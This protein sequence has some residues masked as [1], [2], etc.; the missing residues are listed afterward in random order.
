MRLDSLVF[1]SAKSQFP[2]GEGGGE[3]IIR[4]LL[5]ALS[6]RGIQVE[7]NGAWNP[8]KASL[9]EKSLVELGSVLEPTE[10]EGGCAYTLSYP[11]RLVRREAFAR[12]VETR[13]AESDCEVVLVQAVDSW[14]AIEAARRLGRVPIFYAQN[15][16]ELESYPEADSLP[17]V[18]ANSRYFQERLREQYSMPVELL[19][20]AVDLDKYR[21]EENS[22]RYI[23]MINPVVI[24][25]IAYVLKLALAHPDREFLVVEG[26]GTPPE[27][28][29]LIERIG[30]VTWWD[31]QV[32]MRA[33]YA[34]TDILLV[35]SQWNEAFG[36]V[37]TEAQINGIPVLASR[38][39]GIPESLGSGGVLVEEIQNP[40][41]WTKGLAEVVLRY[42]ELSALA[43]EHAAQFSSDRAAERLLE[44]VGNLES[45]G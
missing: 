24:K 5:L 43:R 22:R 42:D 8:E 23:T 31:K 9:L 19:Y 26:W 16:L 45:G 36:R 41:A 30:N 28:L 39:G 29:S 27:I 21:I 13:I 44:I 38:V 40:E 34:Q 37:I 12:L 3:T 14:E 11:T 4:D 15:G 17:L 18:L 25:G 7:A 32:D 10:V 1:A 2:I 20:P 6:E 35:P 33:V